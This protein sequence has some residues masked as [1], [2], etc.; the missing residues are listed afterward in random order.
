MKKLILLIIFINFLFLSTFSQSNS[1]VTSNYESKNTV[2]LSLGVGG[3]S[4]I[5]NV[6]YER[7]I[8]QTNDAFLSSLWIKGQGGAWAVW[9]SKGTQFGLAAV[10]LSG[11][12][13]NHFE[14]GL[15]I[16][17]L[18]DKAGYSSGVNNYSAGY[19]D[20]HPTKME[21]TD[22][23]V[24]ANIGY[25]YQRPDESIVFRTGIAFPEGVYL[26][27]GFAF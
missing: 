10:G 13:N 19:E 26:S 11:Q 2:Y 17:S 5:L 7:K 21:Y 20:K 15:G 4:Y 25:R 24:Y 18:Y 8:V 6:N 1:L 3:M 16:T 14:Y 23:M 22:F 27:F 9:D 12:R